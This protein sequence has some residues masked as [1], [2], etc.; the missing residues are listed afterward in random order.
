MSEQRNAS[1]KLILRLND[2]K[3]CFNL[4]GM[5]TA[6]NPYANTSEIAKRNEMMVP[7]R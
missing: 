2:S 1:P 6:Y 7:K 3:S 4:L 5:K